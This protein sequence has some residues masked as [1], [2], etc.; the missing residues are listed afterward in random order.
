[1]PSSKSF[2]F[3]S[4][5]FLHLLS[6][7]FFQ[8][9]LCSTGQPPAL[10]GVL[11]PEDEIEPRGSRP[12][13]APKPPAEAAQAATPGEAEEGG[14]SASVG[15]AAAAG[16]AAAAAAAPH[17][18]GR[19]RRVRHQEGGFGEKEAAAAGELSH[20]APPTEDSGGEEEDAAAAAAAASALRDTPKD[21]LKAARECVVYEEVSGLMTAVYSARCVM[22]VS[23]RG[24]Y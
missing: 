7:V 6:F 13:S 23:S 21:V 12:Q 14:V 11:R 24:W 8:A 20:A 2:A 19:E 22:F 17:V 16:A 15:T 9:M 3:H 1:M 18:D 10:L 5:F 4:L